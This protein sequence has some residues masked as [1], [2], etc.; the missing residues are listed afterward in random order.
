M[1]RLSWTVLFAT[2]GIT[3][4]T[5][6]PVAAAA[7]TVVIGVDGTGSVGDPQSIVKQLAGPGAIIIDYP[8]SIF[9]VG[10]YTY[11]ESVRRGIAA[12]QAQIVAAHTARPEATVHLIGHSQGSRVA[13]DAIAELAAA[14]VDTS[15]I[16]A[17]LYA[18]PR[19]PGSGVEVRMAGRSIPG[20]TMTGERG[21]F[22]GATVRQHCNPADPICDFPQDIP[23]WLR[24]PANYVRL[25]GNYGTT[26]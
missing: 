17:D 7:D 22:G 11:D 18:D 9:P 8:G 1:R 15:F 25:H 3:S 20:Y 14:G 12:T 21:P 19:H 24:I 26:P 23:G 4:G 5:L 16:T 10:L 2:I 13:G 6:T